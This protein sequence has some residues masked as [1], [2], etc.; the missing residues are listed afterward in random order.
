[1]ALSEFGSKHLHVPQHEGI[2]HHT[3]G[4]SADIDWSP[5]SRTRASKCCQL[6]LCTTLAH[7]LASC[8]CTLSPKTRTARLCHPSASPLTGV[9]QVR[10]NSL[11]LCA[12]S[13]T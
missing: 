4:R 12:L 1:M 2:K 9:V 3:L 7:L 8:T 6:A 5:Q 13:C 11:D 10:T